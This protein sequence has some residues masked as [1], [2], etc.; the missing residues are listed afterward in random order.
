MDKSNQSQKTSVLVVDDDADLARSTALILKRHGYN[1][2]IAADGMSAIAQVEHN[3]FDIALMDIKMP[4][5]DG[6]D[7]YKRIK[8]LQPNIA[9]IMMTGFSI[10]DRIQEALRAGAL[11]VLTKP[12]DLDRLLQLIEEAVARRASLV[13][14][15]DDYPDTCAT[16]TKI[17]ERKGHR[18]ASAA[19]GEQAIALVK[20]NRY[21]IIFIDLKLPT[22]DGLQTYLAIREL[23]PA[24]TV[25]MMTGY[26]EE[27]DTLVETAL[28]SSASAC[29]YKPFDPEQVVT[30]VEEVRQKRH[31]KV[32]E[33]LDG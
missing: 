30:L 29:L 6:V 3:P 20:Q 23:D 10:E 33:V 31:K 1:V 32:Y 16:L 28:R 22:I 27:M 24:V 19:N 21:N 5:I 15:V 12:L 17:L 8:T 11:A 25:V 7:A 26:R 13:L 2:S 4:G 9:A 14:V 18:V